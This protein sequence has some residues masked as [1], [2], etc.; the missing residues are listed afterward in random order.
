MKFGIIFANAGPLGDPDVTTGLAQLAEEHGFES[1]W[2]VEHVLERARLTHAM[3]TRGGVALEPPPLSA[4]PSPPPV[5]TLVVPPAIPD[6]S[7]VSGNGHDQP[8]DVDIGV[9]S[10]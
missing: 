7:T 4:I 3:R 8:A 9:S 10:A 6:P 5:A 2:T 1:L